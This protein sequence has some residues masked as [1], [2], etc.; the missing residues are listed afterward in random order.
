MN[1]QELQKQL[2]ELKL[3][4]KQKEA[5][6]RKQIA[7]Q[8]RREEDALIKCIGKLAKQRFYTL[9]SF[10]DFE[11]FFN[12]ISVPREQL[13]TSKTNTSESKKSNVDI[14]KSDSKKKDAEQIAKQY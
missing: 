14:P 2:D 7:K 13:T 12:S 1:T 11:K 10:D 8:K 5:E 4:N 3:A 9:K 6:L